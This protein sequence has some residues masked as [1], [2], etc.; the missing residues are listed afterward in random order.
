MIHHC[1][2]LKM[3][4]PDLMLAQTAR[5]YQHLS[6]D[7]A[8]HNSIIADNLS[9]HPAIISSCHPDSWTYL[10]FSHIHSHQMIT[11]PR[12]LFQNLPNKADRHDSKSWHDIDPAQ[13]LCPSSITILK[14][15]P[16]PVHPE[17]RRTVRFPHPGITP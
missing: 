2:P 7:F 6:A 9:S 14:H 17:H 12:F 15:P 11:V 3:H 13:V 8:H 16:P 5:L 10:G 4:S 1:F